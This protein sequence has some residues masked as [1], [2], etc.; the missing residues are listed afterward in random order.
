[1]KTHDGKNGSKTNKRTR[2]HASEVS[3]QSV[4]PKQQCEV[5]H[6]VKVQA[7]QTTTEIQNHQQLQSAEPQT[8]RPPAN[9]APAPP[10]PSPQQTANQLVVSPEIEP[11][12]LPSAAKAPETQLISKLEQSD[13]EIWKLIEPKL[14]ELFSQKLRSLVEKLVD[15]QNEG[16]D[17]Q[18]KIQILES[19]ISKLNTANSYLLRK[20][21]EANDVIQSLSKQ[22]LELSERVKILESRAIAKSGN[23]NSASTPDPEISKEAQLLLSVY[24][25]FHNEWKNPRGFQNQGKNENNT[26][27]E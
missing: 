21:Q 27:Y 25:F 20:N 9:P 3:T 16:I 15:L 6:T 5:N 22:I 19:E 12:S 17:S 24:N 2:P 1:M 8:P 23:S 14:L 18:T 10:S 4:D 11:V 26:K 7:K 13:V